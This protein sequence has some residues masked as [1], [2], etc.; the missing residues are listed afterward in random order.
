MPNLPPAKGAAN[1]GGIARHRVPAG[2]QPSQRRQMG[3]GMRLVAGLLLAGVVSLL[4]G[5][6][7]VH[8]IA[9]LPCHGEGLACNIDTAIGAYAV[10]ILVVAGLIVFGLIAIL[11]RKRVSLKAG[12]LLLLAPLGAFTMIGLIE[13]WSVFGVDPYPDLRQA[14]S[15]FAPAALAVVSQWAVLSRIL[16]PE[17]PRPVGPEATEAPEPAAPAPETKPDASEA[18]LRPAASV[19]HFP[20]E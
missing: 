9:L 18:P 6:A 10:P 14:L 12:M 15:V 11:A 17:P 5:A 7:A 19:P 16:R 20:T 4:V 8:V 3:E 13:V 2:G 1:G